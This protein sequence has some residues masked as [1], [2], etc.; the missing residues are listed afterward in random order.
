[1]Q[2]RAVTLALT[3]LL[4]AVPGAV[5]ERVE[6]TRGTWPLAPTPRVVAPFDPPAEK[7][8]AGHRGVDLAGTPGQRVLSALAGTVGHASSIAGRGVVV[9]RHDDGTRTTYEPVIAAVEVGA[10][11]AAGDQIGWL[12]VAAS[13]CL[14]TA[15]L[16]WGRRH[17]D[18]Y[19]DPLELVGRPD[20]RLFPLTEPA[21][22]PTLPGVLLHPW[23]A[24][25]QARGW[26]WV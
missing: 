22:G 19:L 18:A 26:A 2:L 6:P 24:W 13:H 4:T 23:D 15:C 21:P 20:T 25:R 14:P 9:V 16:H 12:T 10:E 17:G 3:L 7:W 1:M 8:R 5:D 11:V